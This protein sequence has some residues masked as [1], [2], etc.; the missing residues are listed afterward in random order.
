LFSYFVHLFFSFSCHCNQVATDEKK[1]SLAEVEKHLA[2]KKEAERKQREQEET[3]RRLDEEMEAKKRAGET[4]FLT[5]VFSILYFLQSFLHFDLFCFRFDRVFCLLFVFSHL[6]EA[7]AQS[8]E[9]QKKEEEE[10][11]RK[12][13]EIK[14]QA[15]E[16][17]V[18][19]DSW[20][21]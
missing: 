19:A 6:I 5:K 17:K 15:E 16:R 10:Y 1:A 2:V 4:F 8:E 12:M 14:K 7:R 21:S 18:T 3:Q 20:R 11:A 13:E 9:K